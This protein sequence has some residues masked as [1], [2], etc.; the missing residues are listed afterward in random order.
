MY[1]RFFNMKGYIYKITNK[2]NNKIYIGSS[3]NIEKRKNAHFN[4]LRNRKHHSIHLQRAYDKY[5]E[6]AFVFTVV[7][8]Y[9]LET[10]NEL[11]LLEER[12]INFGNDIRVYTKNNI[13][14]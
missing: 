1:T 3:F 8:E 5:G 10:E 2:E 11:R 14:N 13:N 6:K 7:K 12:Y 4:A 9:D